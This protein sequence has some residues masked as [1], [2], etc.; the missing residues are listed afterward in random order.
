MTAMQGRNIFLVDLA[1]IL[2][3][4]GPAV[5]LQRAVEGRFNAVWIRIG[6]GEGLDRNMRLD[7]LPALR[8]SL[9]EAG[10]ELWGWH[11][12]FCASVEAAKREAAFVLELAERHGLAGV[13]LDVEK[14]PENPRFRGGAREAGIYAG[15]I[16]EGLAAKGRGVALSSHDQP[17]LHRDVPYDALLAHVHDVSPQVYYRGA[18]AGTR[19]AKCLRDYR[20]LLPEAEFAARF[21]PTGNIT[22]GHDVA[23]PSAEAC[24][25]GARSFMDL[26]GQA[27]AKAYGFWCWDSAPEEIWRF[28]KDAPV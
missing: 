14:T 10:V 20:A 9:A 28:F 11:V 2:R 16:A 17:A 22:V 15:R 4:I 24:L 26:A 8:E 13:A 7:Q 19:F 3:P 6:R 25:A 23:L 5:F 12:A 18:D 21:K 1:A 27:G